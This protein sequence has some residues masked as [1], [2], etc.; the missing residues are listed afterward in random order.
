MGTYY[1][2][3]LV[4][5]TFMSKQEKEN[6]RQ[7]IELDLRHVNEVFSTYIKHS[8]LSLL[9]RAKAGERKKVSPELKE[10]L[11]LSD[12]IS[13]QTQGYFD[14]TVGPLVNAWG[15]GPE[16]KQKRPSAEQLKKLKESVGMDKFVLSPDGMFIKKRQDVYLDLSAVAKGYGVDHVHEMLS[17]KGHK[18]VLVE[19]GGEVKAS[20]L[21]PGGEPWLIGI[22]KPSESLAG[23]VQ[24]V[25]SLRDM[26]MAT[27]GSYR[28]YVKHGDE[29]FSHTIDPVEME[30]ARNN[31]ISVT[32]LGP[33]CAMADAY[34]TAFLAMGDQ[35]A[36]SLAEKLGLPAYFIVKKGAKTA[37]VMTDSFKPF[38][39]GRP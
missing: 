28:N 24:E 25:V 12:K 7:E 31:V 27:S 18:S 39:K 16:G 14:I 32:V 20:G 4:A 3:K 10:L 19:I 29:I 8:D 15:F 2:V 1:S 35:K 33:S 26:A 11:R 37:I 22:E 30:P 9:N 36:L 6:L 38:I 34:A 13:A 17:A 5:D 23:G 21:K